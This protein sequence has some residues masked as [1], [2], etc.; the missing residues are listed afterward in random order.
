MVAIDKP[1]VFDPCPD[2][3]D[4][5]R[6]FNLKV[7][8]DRHGIAVL[9]QVTVTVFDGTHIVVALSLRGLW[10][11]V[12]ALWADIIGFIAIGVFRAAF[13]AIR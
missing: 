6:P 11:F 5:G 8:D 13:W 9:K 1:Y 10:P 2:F 12:R 7:F 4:E 3:D